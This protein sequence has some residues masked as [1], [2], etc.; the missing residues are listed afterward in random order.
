MGLENISFKQALMGEEAKRL[1][2]EEL[3]NGLE[4][5]HYGSFYDSE[6]EMVFI[7][8]ELSDVDGDEIERAMG[9]QPSSY[10]IGTVGVLTD[11]GEFQRNGKGWVY[12]SVP[13]VIRY[14]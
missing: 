3:F 12:I 1:I 8:C 7:K 5:R 14:G 9:I 10:T 11:K 4:I 13:K 2:V 6:N